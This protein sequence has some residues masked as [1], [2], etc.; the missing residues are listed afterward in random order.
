METVS[1]IK[2]RTTEG[3]IVRILLLLPMKCFNLLAFVSIPCIHHIQITLQILLFPEGTDK[4][5]WTT[6]KSREYAKKNGLRDLKNVIYP[7]SA[8]IAYLI[9]KMRQCECTFS[10]VLFLL[11][12]RNDKLL[13]ELEHL[14]RLMLV[15]F[16]PN[17]HI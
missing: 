6:E 14:V 8:G 12:L 15:E 1:D 2:N 11:F 4:S 16:V 17:V 9:T 10:V 3:K 5:P 13:L 7:R